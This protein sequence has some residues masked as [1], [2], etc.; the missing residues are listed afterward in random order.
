MKISTKLL[1]LSEKAVKYKEDP[2]KKSWSQVI[3]FSV[4]NVWFT[5][6]KLENEE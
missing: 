1:A 6:I 3:H 4:K 5:T 2:N